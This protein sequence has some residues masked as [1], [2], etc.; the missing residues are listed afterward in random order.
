LSGRVAQLWRHP[1]KGC[2]AEPVTRT[3]LAPGRAMD[4]DRVWAVAHDAAR[5]APEAPGW[6]PCPNFVRGARTPAVMAIRAETDEAAGRVTLR[7]P[8]RPEIAVD[9][10][11]PADAARLVAW[12]DPLH[13][14][15]RP[16]PAFV[17]RAGARGMTDSDFPSISVLGLAS[18]R[19]LG[20]RLG[21]ALAP[22]RFRGN[23]WIEGLAPWEEFDWLGREIRLGAARLRVRE[24]ITRCKATT[25]D[26]ATGRRDADTLG[27]LEAGWGH[28]DFGV[29]AEVVAGGPV[30]LG[31]PAGPA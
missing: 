5:L 8:D 13:D 15:S 23:V 22:E 28:Q 19:A 2:G 3:T 9:P 10:D 4:W 18:L 31:D 11:A 29:Y 24:R 6:A 7:H 26:P 25:V 16:R 12:L 20:D 30:A 1:I 14:P 21:R 17:L 27:A